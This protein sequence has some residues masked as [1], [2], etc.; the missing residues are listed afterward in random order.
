MLGEAERC[1]HR[2]RFETRRWVCGRGSALG[3]AGGAYSAPLAPLLGIG[4]RDREEGME[5]VRE[6]NGPR[7]RT[8]EERK[9]KEEKGRVGME[10][11]EGDC[12]IGL[13]VRRPCTY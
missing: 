5:W 2:V 11:G 12:I 10:M 13:G 3:P 9:G 4:G 7:G 6:G 1:C 8:G